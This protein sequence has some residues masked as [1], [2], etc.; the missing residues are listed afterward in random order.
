LDTKFPLKAKRKMRQS[1][2]P[3]TCGRDARATAQHDMFRGLFAQPAR[4]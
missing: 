3:K 2:L 4:R 1:A